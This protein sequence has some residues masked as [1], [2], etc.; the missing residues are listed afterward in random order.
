MIRSESFHQRI[1]CF[2]LL[3]SL[4]Y[5]GQRILVNFSLRCFVVSKACY[6]QVLS[7]I[8]HSNTAFLVSHPCCVSTSVTRTEY[9]IAA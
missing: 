9:N 4:R 7:K 1:V 2:H 6:L 3:F 5:K 8:L